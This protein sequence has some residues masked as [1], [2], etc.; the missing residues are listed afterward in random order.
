[1]L[2]GV[3]C[4]MQHPF[5]Y[6]FYLNSHAGIQGTR[7]CFPVSYAFYAVID[8]LV[9]WHSSTVISAAPNASCA[10]ISV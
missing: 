1:M 2:H 5:E 8:T 7:Y 3:W 10:M 4:G 6:A 9:N